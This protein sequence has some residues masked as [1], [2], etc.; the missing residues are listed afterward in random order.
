MIQKV[1]NQYLSK[2][3]NMKTENNFD[4]FSLGSWKETHNICYSEEKN[5]PKQ[6]L[7]PRII[8]KY[9]QKGRMKE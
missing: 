4:A 9:N 3:H 8:F 5:L 2:Q 7:H 1:Q 6:K